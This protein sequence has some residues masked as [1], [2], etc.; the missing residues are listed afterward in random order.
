M[1]SS[2]P[3][4]LIECERGYRDAQQRFVLG[5]H[6]GAFDGF[7]SIYMEKCDFRDVAQIVHDYY[8]MAKDDWIAKYKTR[9]SG[10]HEAA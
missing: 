1:D 9:F 5:D 4:W 2:K 7:K 6:E 8:D 10:P 3:F